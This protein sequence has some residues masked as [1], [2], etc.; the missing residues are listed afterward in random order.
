MPTQPSFSPLTLHALANVISGGPGNGPL[1][2]I[3]IYRSGPKIESLVRDCNLDLQ[4]GSDSRLPALIDFLRELAADPRG[5]AGI[6]RLI[7]RV[8]DPRDYLADPSRGDA[9]IE[10]LNAHLASDEFELILDGRRPRLREKGAAGAVVSVFAA[11]AEKLNFDT[12]IREIG[13]ALE[14]AER[15]PEDAVT[16]A[17]SIVEAVCRSILIELALPLPAKRDIDGVVRAVQGPLGLMP[18]GTDLPSEIAADVRQVLGGLTTV[19]KG[20]GS[21]RTH[22]GDAHGRE[23]GYGRI[24]ARIARLAIHTSS[25]LALFLIETWELKFKRE[26]HR[27]ADD[28]RIPEDGA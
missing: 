13:R 10:H 26:L 17:C 15:D 9:V 18:G 5:R 23:R 28:P 12:V 14:S 8:A 4:I 25:T 3:G 20:I 27:G 21:L 2:P 24:D 6:V 1:K 7:E 11:K 16:A 22:A 19:A